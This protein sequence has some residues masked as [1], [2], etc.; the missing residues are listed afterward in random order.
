MAVADPVNV[1][2]NTLSMN[3][4]FRIAP[5]LLLTI[6]SLFATLPQA[7]IYNPLSRKLIAVNKYYHI[8]YSYSA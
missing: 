4:I 1:G 3:Y 5:V 2:S 7:S 6:A 8:S